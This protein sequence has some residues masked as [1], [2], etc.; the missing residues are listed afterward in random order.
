[1]G[2][3][4]VIQVA[5]WCGGHGWS[6]VVSGVIVAVDHTVRTL[7][8]DASQKCLTRVSGDITCFL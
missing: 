7:V 2:R 5:R 1:M 6:V 4:M 8:I 3:A